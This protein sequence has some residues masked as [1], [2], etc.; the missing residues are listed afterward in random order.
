MFHEK[1]KQVKE[2]KLSEVLKNKIRIDKNAFAA[3]ELMQLKN[4]PETDRIPYRLDYTTSYSSVFNLPARLLAN[5]DKEM[6]RKI[7]FGLKLFV[8]YQS[9]VEYWVST[10]EIHGCLARK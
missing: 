7:S 8:M 3:S 10:F 4:I 9:H 6:I 2:V 1:Y 5:V